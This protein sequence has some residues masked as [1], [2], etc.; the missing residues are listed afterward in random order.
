MSKK[1]KDSIWFKVA[2]LVVL[3]VVW[4]L[5]LAPSGCNVKVGESAK[6]EVMELGTAKNVEIS[7]KFNSIDVKVSS[8]VTEIVAA[9]NGSGRSFDQ[10]STSRDGDTIRISIDT[11]NNWWEFWKMGLK[12]RTLEVMIPSS[13][14]LDNLT[15]KSVSGR[16][17][18]ESVGAD[19][20]IDVSSVSGS[21]D[22]DPLAAKNVTVAS[23]SGGIDVASIKADKASVVSIS[24]SVELGWFDGGS[25]TMSSTSGHVDLYDSGDFDSLDLRSVSGHIDAEVGCK[26]APSVVASSTSGSVEINGED[27]GSKVH[28]ETAGPV[29]KAE[30]SSGGIEIK[31][32]R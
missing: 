3:A 24:G 28:L 18:V 1:F 12:S 20:S 6:G 13:M 21:V 7:T 4:I 11:E 5:W 17:V 25:L 16:V 2:L 27:Y 9:A 23:T 30:T 29:V 10:V 31:F 14:V 8:Q 15:V 32:A 22:A 26:S 19:D